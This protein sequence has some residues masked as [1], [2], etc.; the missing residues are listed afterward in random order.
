MMK[1][2]Y[3]VRHRSETRHFFHCRLPWPT[4]WVVNR[5]GAVAK[6]LTPL[7]LGPAI[8]LLLLS[9]AHGQRRQAAA[10][11]LERALTEHA[12]S[13]EWYDQLVGQQASVVLRSGERIEDATIQGFGR[14]REK[15]LFRTVSLQADDESKTRRLAGGLL[16]QLAVGDVTYRV[17][18]VPSKRAFA[19]I[20]ENA[21]N[22]AITKR[23]ATQGLRLW[24]KLA[25]Q[26]QEKHVQELKGFL[27]EVATHFAPLQMQLHETA[28]FLFLTDM[29]PAQITPY[30]ASLDT[31]NVQLG[32]AFGFEPGTNV[33]Y[34]KAAVV[35]FVNKVHYIELERRFMDNANAIG[36]Q[37]LCH[38]DSRGKVIVG[39]YRG[40]NP[41]YFASLLVH[42]T[43]HGY[44]HRYRSPAR[45][46][47]WLNEGIADW[48]AGVAVPSSRTVLR[49]QKTAAD[50]LRQQGSFHGRFFDSPK[51]GPM[52]YGAAS[53]CVDLLIRNS[54]EGFR[55]FID[56]IKEGLPWEHSLQRAYGLTTA[57]LAVTYGRTIGIPRLTP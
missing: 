20:D 21:R 8:I 50:H 25:R 55:V 57:D 45:V 19:L 38:Q 56:G 49:R 33:W 41:A 10:P 1:S 6:I 46:P 36:A 13:S 12:I 48:I 26:E 2:M 24:P 35:A 51:I 53:T 16:F 40:A 37:G 52:Q 18:R 31:M 34:G 27:N 9:H 3:R 30:L 43:A 54:P 23:L 42:E 28:Y 44:V 39:C 17:T 29:P 32:Q 7:W 47:S 15:A 4:A 14:G 11:A 5:F 22:K